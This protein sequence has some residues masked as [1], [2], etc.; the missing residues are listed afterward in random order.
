MKAHI[1]PEKEVFLLYKLGE[2]TEKGQKLRQAL[3]QMNIEVIT[4]T[5][6]MLLESVG[7][8]AHMDGFASYG[9]VYQGEP[10]PY[11][12][13]VMKVPSRARLNQILSQLQKEG[14]RVERKAIITPT[15][16][17]WPFRKLYEEV[18]K[19]HELMNQGRANP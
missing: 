12:M 11:E 8:C 3:S 10:L 14:L 5:D 19:E 7:F 16:R 9:E 1:R 17:E 13:L 6:D 2:D 15:N 18:S 4:V